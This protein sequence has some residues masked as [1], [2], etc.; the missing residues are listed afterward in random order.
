MA[1][2]LKN[3]Y[4]KMS[5]KVK[6]HR[7]LN[8]NGRAAVKES[9]IINGV[10][11]FILEAS[12]PSSITQAARLLRSGEVIAMPTDTVYGLACSATDTKAIQKIYEIKGREENKP[13]AICV[14]NFQQLRKY[15]EADHL[16]DE[17]LSLLLPGP[18][19]LVLNRSKHLNNPYLNPGIHKIGI[20]IPNFKFIQ[21][22]SLDF[23]SPIALTSANKSSE[24]STLNISEF[25]KLWPQLGAIFDGGQLGQQDEQ[26]AASTVIDLSSEGVYKIIRRGVCMK[27]TS[28]IMNKFGI[29][30]IL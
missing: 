23:C 20:R 4:Q 2:V 1:F 11:A 15:G 25:E 7:S 24:L 19:T 27:H 3:I 29:K 10:T 6:L 17:L 14:G 28:D 21:D 18:V 8:N 13:V 12:E 30:E 9:K 26:R 5:S 22:V 16:S